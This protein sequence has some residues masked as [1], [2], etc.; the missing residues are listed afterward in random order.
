M[1]LVVDCGSSCVKVGFAGDDAP[2]Y[3]LP[4]AL[5]SLPRKELTDTIE[6]NSKD[7]GNI[8]PI[9]RGTVVD[10]EEPMTE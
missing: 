7:K 8:F 2:S 10:F 9:Q 5:S 3:L 6:F 1:D 4:S